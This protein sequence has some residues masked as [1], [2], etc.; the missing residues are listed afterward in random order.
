[1]IAHRRARVRWVSRR[2]SRLPSS[3]ARV[4]LAASV[5][6]SASFT[7]TLP[8]LLMRQ[9]PSKRCGLSCLGHAETD[10]SAS[11]VVEVPSDPRDVAIG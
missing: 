10:L 2:G 7:W 11:E 4:E 6:N 9:S 3:A 5:I 8:H 1:M